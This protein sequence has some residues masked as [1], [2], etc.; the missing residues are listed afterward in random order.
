MWSLDSL[1]VKIDDSF[2]FPDSGVLAICERAWSLTAESCNVK[3]I[4]AELLCF[5]FYFEWAKR[6][7]ED[8]PNDIIWLGHDVGFPV[9]EPS[10]DKSEQM[11]DDNMDQSEYNFTRKNSHKKFGN[12][13]QVSWNPNKIWSMIE[14]L[15]SLDVA[16]RFDE[17]CSADYTRPT[18]L[19]QTAYLRAYLAASLYGTSVFKIFAE[20][21]CICCFFHLH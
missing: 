18:S 2:L 10:A 20:W 6:R 16:S 8:A 4:P 9:P 15:Y 12:L 19:S 17:I 21:L 13:E 5:C 3:F 14:P 1:D 11:K 7:V